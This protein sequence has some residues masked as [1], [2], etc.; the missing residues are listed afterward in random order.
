I[1]ITP[2]GLAP[3]KYLELGSSRAGGW[4]L[5]GRPMQLVRCPSN[6]LPHG[7]N[8]P[9]T[10]RAASSHSRSVGSLFP[11]FLQKNC[12]SSIVSGAG[13]SSHGGLADNCVSAEEVSFEAGVVRF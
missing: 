5:S 4:P 2:N 13:Q 8:R 1:S 3:A 7:Y 12:A 10:P 6:L 9:S 11:C